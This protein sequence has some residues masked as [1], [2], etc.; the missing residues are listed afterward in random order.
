VGWRAREHLAGVGA[1]GQQ[2][3]VAKVRGGAIGGAL[4][5]VAVHL[6]HRGVQ[7]DRHWPITWARAGRPRPGQD[8]LGEPV[9]PADLPEGEGA[10]EG[11]QVEGAMTR[12]P[13]TWLVAPQRSTSALAT[14][15]GVVEAA[16]ELVQVWE[17]PIEN[18]PS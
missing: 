3:V 10:Q 6:A 13:S 1:G 16:V 4:L 11:P 7:V 18:V 14:A 17:D 9:E 5:V 15:W 12:W 2:R 8:L